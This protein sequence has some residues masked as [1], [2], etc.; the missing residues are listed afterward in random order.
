MPKVT[1]PVG[2]RADYNDK[3]TT[4]KVVD[5][6]LLGLLGSR[7]STCSEIGNHLSI[8]QGSVPL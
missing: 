7:C 1:E 6:I 2:G 8:L 4:K 5:P 3:A